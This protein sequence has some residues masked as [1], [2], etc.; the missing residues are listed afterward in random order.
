MLF[1]EKG[2]I[3]AGCAVLKDIFNR[4][5]KRAPLKNIFNLL[6]AW[7]LISQGNSRI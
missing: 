6:Q 4:G 7:C 5:N 1:F 2:A 3:L